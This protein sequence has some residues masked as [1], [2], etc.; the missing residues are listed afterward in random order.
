MEYS[1]AFVKI[2][3][4]SAWSY[5][6]DATK[7]AEVQETVSKEKVPR[8][9]WEPGIEAGYRPPYKTW[10]YYASSLLQ[11]HNET[12]NVWTH[13]IGGGVILLYL[14][15]YHILLDFWNNEKTWPF[16]AF[17]LSSLLCTIF[18]GAAHLLHSKS[19]YVH[20]VAFSFDYAGAGLYCF[21][22]MTFS[23]YYSFDD[24]MV[25]QFGPYVMPINAFLSVISCFSCSYGKTKYSLHH[26]LRRKLWF[27]IPCGM[28]FILCTGPPA[29]RFMKSVIFNSGEILPSEIVS[30]ELHFK[31]S[32]IFLIAAM[33]FISHI[34]E[35]YIPGAFD[36]L[37]HSHQAWHV[38]LVATMSCQFHAAYN[39]ILHTQYSSDAQIQL[40]SN[41]AVFYYLAF[42][43]LA[44]TIVIV[45]NSFLAKRVVQE[46][47][48]EVAM[49]TDFVIQNG[50]AKSMR[51]DEKPKRS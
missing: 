12:I 44:D 17:I 31:S 10:G 4:S 7:L 6:R 8:P 3:P 20:Y 16:L 18:S 45:V 13:L 50:A 23:F 43:C 39:D 14:Y 49:A 37:C 51:K 9:T 29:Y 2:K 36:N 26:V 25:K 47:N 30:C 32:V 24:D 40:P 41:G 34:P 21:G 5:V 48:Q 1:A 15:H 11:F 28:H 22:C 38:L 42:I 35:V 19:A 33:F 27:I 46:E